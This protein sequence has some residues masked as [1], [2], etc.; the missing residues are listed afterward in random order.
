MEP[1]ENK[2]LT[3]LFVQYKTTLDTFNTIS[4]KTINDTHAQYGSGVVVKTV[5]NSTHAQCKPTRLVSN[6]CGQVTVGISACFSTSCVSL[7]MDG[8]EEREGV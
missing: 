7:S 8:W 5:K 2:T 4:C 1:S 3:K 6:K